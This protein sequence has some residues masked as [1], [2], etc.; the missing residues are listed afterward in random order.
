MSTKTA[1]GTRDRRGES[2]GGG[3]TQR[4]RP[5]TMW[6]GERIRGTPMG[7]RR[8][9]KRRRM[10]RGGRGGGLLQRV[11]GSRRWTTGTATAHAWTR[12][13]PTGGRTHPRPNAGWRRRIG[14]DVYPFLWCT[15]DQCSGGED[16][17][18]RQ[19]KHHG[20]LG[21]EMYRP[22]VGGLCAP[23]RTHRRFT[24][25]HDVPSRCTPIRHTLLPSVPIWKVAYPTAVIRL[26][27][28]LFH[29][30]VFVIMRKER[31]IGGSNTKFS[32]F[33]SSASLLNRGT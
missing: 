19:M 8:R 2:G 17:C 23:P 11:S 10:R 27:I 31:P 33:L 5:T 9:R 21:S 4:G 24:G 29:H 13:C 6:A 26:L 22:A 3:E 18:S 20:P 1:V 30:T 14:K 7:I 15:M 28:H 25:F 32:F 16:T 12:V